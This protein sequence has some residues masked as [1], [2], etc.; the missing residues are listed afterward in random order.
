MCDAAPTHSVVLA[1]L[2]NDLLKRRVR[3]DETKL[4]WNLVGAFAGNLAAQIESE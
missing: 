4:D 1:N 3:S 2:I